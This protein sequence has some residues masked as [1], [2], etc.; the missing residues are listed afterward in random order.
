MLGALTDC[1][2][3]KSPTHLLSEPC[4]GQPIKKKSLLKWKSAYLRKLRS[5]VKFQYNINNHNFEL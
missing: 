5:L 2:S 1:F 4:G 3:T